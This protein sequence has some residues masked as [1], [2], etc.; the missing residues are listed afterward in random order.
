M[1]GFLISSIIFKDIE[2]GT[3]SVSRFF[4]HRTRRILPALTVCVIGTFPLALLFSNTPFFTDYLR[5]ACAT[6]LSA[7]NIYF[8]Q[9][10]SGYFALDSS[11]IP[12][13]H[14]W[15]L[16]LEEQFYI[17]MPFVLLFISK[18]PAKNSIFFLIAVVISFLV[19]R[20]GE[21]LVSDKFI[22]Y[23]L[24]TRMWEFGI[25]T[26]VALARMHFQ[27][28]ISAYLGSLLSIGSVSFIVFAFYHYS[29]NSYFAEKSLFVCIATS[30]FILTANHNILVRKIFKSRASRFI[31]K[32]SYSTYLW[33]W[34]IIVFTNI[35]EL[36]HPISVSNWAKD[37]V[38][39]SITL[40]V[41]T[42]SW[43]YIETPF[44]HLKEWPSVLKAFA[45]Y[46]TGAFG[47]VI[48][49][50]L[51]Y[52]VEE[53]SFKIDDKVYNDASYKAIIEGKY[54]TIGPKGD[55]KFIL[56]GDSHARAM[57]FLFEE[58]ANENKTPGIIG[59]Y[60]WTSPL[61]N[62]VRKG[63]EDNPPFAQAWFEYIKNRD[64]KNIVLISR[65]DSFY[66]SDEWKHRDPN[67]ELTPERIANELRKLVSSLLKDG[68]KVFV[69]DQVPE[70]VNNPV[71]ASRVVPDYAE[72]ANTKHD[73]HFAKN[74]LASINSHNLSILDPWPYL[75]HG[76]KILVQTNGNLL[77]RDE[78]HLS[79]HGALKLKPLFKEVF[80]SY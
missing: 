42:L 54:P 48:V 49:G 23:M 38:I 76:G 66:N 70:F 35:L 25:G 74:A 80:N 73:V 2:A 37:T 40:V 14:T 36:Y 65:W 77:W 4:L 39:I 44:R 10:T 33:H 9:T 58:L 34:P 50:F 11:F 52:S 13:L 43:K 28:T 5:S 6:L 59:T 24:P 3:F 63:R 16:G 32:I 46:A 71:L 57:A 68:R 12:L 51:F 8:W 29:G 60:T 1:S 78:N 26:T 53:N 31:G 21:S 30:I 15:T 41:S 7:S 27:K 62:V 69:L 61:L 22:F 19:C 75:V 47:V 20:Y 64:I 67:Q 17:L 79:R 45:P 72:R 18:R 55:P 56:I